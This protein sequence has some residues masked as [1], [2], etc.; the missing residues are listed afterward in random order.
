MA[1]DIHFGNDARAKIANG[2]KKL[3]DTVRVTMGP[4]G[5]N[6]ILEKSFGAP[7]VTNDGVTIAKEISFEDKFENMGAQLAKE[8]ATKTNDVAGD[9]TST[10]T[11]LADAMIREGLKNVAAGANPMAIKIGIDI[12]TANVVQQLEEMQEPVDSVEKIEQ[13]AT[14]SAQ[15]SEV[16]KIIAEVFESVG[17]DGVVTVEEGQTMGL[18]KEVVEGMQF[19]NGYLSPYM[20]S[21]PETM[22][23]EIENAKILLTDKKISSIQEI[24]P[25]LEQ[26]AQSGDK[27]LVIISENVESEALATLIVNKLR[28][29]FNVLAV[30]APG[31]GERRKAMLQDIAILTGARV[32]SEEI[33][34]KIENAGMAD[35]GR[36]KK[37]VAGQDFT[38]IIDGAGEAK[39]I[40]N[41]VK[42]IEREMDKSKSEY[43]REKLA[44]RRAK[45][46]GGVAVIKVGAATEVELKEKKHRIEDA[47]LATKAATEEG[48]VAGGGTALLRA[49]EVLKKL[50]IKDKEQQVGVEIVMR[51]LQAPCRQ[52]AENSGFEGSVVIADVLRS[53]KMADGFDAAEGV[54]KDL[55]KAGIIDPK[56]VTRSALQN[57][58]SIAGTFLTTEAAIAELPQK[59]SSCSHDGGQMPGGMG[60]MPGM[61]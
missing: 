59:E 33:G 11:I 39:D 15:N 10:A 20:V 43:D 22:T 36:A 23:A 41:R 2:V 40:E 25:L 5:R 12:A 49:G 31:F 44:E 42:E 26:V 19:D 56:K 29:T 60:G 24:L 21:N 7:M 30:K 61:M 27:N 51:A 13:I 34:L 37:V 52:I 55:I 45:L 32:V 58:A 53:S 50:I 3:A 8:V 38:M 9:G 18:E 48:I 54:V 28:G 46:A 16:G 1:K 47:V 4:K 57:A 35:L 14:I 6:V 17:A